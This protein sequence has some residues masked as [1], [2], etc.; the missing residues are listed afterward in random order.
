MFR[1]SRINMTEMVV[2]ALD[3]MGACNGLVPQAIYL[4]PRYEPF[5]HDFKVQH[6]TVPEPVLCVH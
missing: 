6:E 5:T 3:N 2:G 1:C 4:V